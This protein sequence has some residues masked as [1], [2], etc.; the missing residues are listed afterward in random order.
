MYSCSTTLN[1][2]CVQNVVPFLFACIGVNHHA[3]KDL[4]GKMT[5]EGMLEVYQD[6]HQFGS[7]KDQDEMLK[8][9]TVD[10]SGCDYGCS[11]TLVDWMY[12][13]CTVYQHMYTYMHTQ[14]YI[15]W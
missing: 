8:T 2:C 5:T 14:A 7:D 9:S 13:F 12:V 3:S 1:Y 11:Y 6:V 4:M 10:L 15:A